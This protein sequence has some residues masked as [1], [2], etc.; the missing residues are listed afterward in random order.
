MANGQNAKN[1]SSQKKK[2]A[3]A[4]TMIAM[5]APMKVVNAF[6]E[7]K[8]SATAEP[9]TQQAKDLVKRE[10]K[11]AIKT[12]NGKNAKGKFFPKKRL[13]MGKM[14]TAM[15]KWMKNYNPLHSAINK[16][17]CVRGLTKNVVERKDGSLAMPLCTNNTIKP[18]KMMKAIVTE[19]TT[20]AM[21]M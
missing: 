10:S 2:F 18:M 8:K 1:K 14:T 6:L 15:A 3:T 16:K 7:M 19:R 13:A 21:V 9:Q 11:V 4:R 20:I 5:V 17:V 12:A